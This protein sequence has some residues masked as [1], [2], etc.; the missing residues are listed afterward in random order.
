MSK[1]TIR[2]IAIG[3]FVT[4]VGGIFVAWV[5]Q[6]GKRFEPSSALAN[7]PTPIIITAT[8]GYPHISIQNRLVCPVK[9]YI[10]SKYVNTVAEGGIAVF[11]IESFPARVTFETVNFVPDA[12][13]MSGV[14]EN[15]HDGQNLVIT[16]VIGD[17]FYFF[18]RINNNSSR[19]CEIV[20]D[21]GYVTEKRPGILRPY[22]QN[23][24]MGYY[25]LFSNSNVTLYCNDQEYFWGI[26][27]NQI[28]PP[29]S[30][31]EIVQPE[32]GLLELMLNP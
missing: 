10:N 9:I 21:D 25:R 24:S 16:N 3:L 32:S 12:D 27:P 31:T 6:E 22:A 15:V 8:P 23:V 26:R 11:V 14:F 30:I 19:E 28:Q 20:I 2:E 5:I 13:Y 29:G 4:I 7:T 1:S 18:I 17:E